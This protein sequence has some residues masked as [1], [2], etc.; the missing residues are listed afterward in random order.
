MNTAIVGKII[1]VF[2]RDPAKE[3]IYLDPGIIVWGIS[4]DLSSISIEPWFFISYLSW[5]IGFE[6]TNNNWM[7][8]I[9]LPSSEIW[10][11]TL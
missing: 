2:L 1:G 5:Y 6:G 3:T 10:Q 7:R 8:T 4:L 11:I 9:V